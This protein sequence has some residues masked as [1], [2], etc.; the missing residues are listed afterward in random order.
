MPELDFHPLALQEY[1]ETTTYYLREASSTIATRFVGVVE[2]A[3]AAIVAMP[4]RSP[5]IDEPQIRRMLLK[6]FPYAIY[7]HH[8]ADSDRIIIL[9]IMHCRR[10]PG[11][12]KDRMN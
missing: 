6:G 1:V 7:Y 12:W 11:Y 8:Y 2:G 9:A 4:Q 3:I 10:M 5:I